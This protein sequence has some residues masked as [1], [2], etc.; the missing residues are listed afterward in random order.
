MKPTIL[1]IES[2][3]SDRPSLIEGLTRKGY[4]VQSALNGAS[5]LKLMESCDPRAA[6]VDAASMRT[7][8]SR[9]CGSLR[10]KKKDLP[11][12]LIL[13]PGEDENENARYCADEVLYLPFTLQK[14]INRLRPYVSLNENK[15]M[16][17][18]PLKLDLKEHWV[19]CQGRKARLTPRLFILMQKLM[20]HP[21]ELL[22]RDELFTTLWETD[23]L[24]DTRSLDVHISWLRKA[25]EDDPRNPQFIRTERGLGYRLEI[26]KPSRPK[27][28]RR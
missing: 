19:H 5:A 14:L 12:L 8:G 21:G 16:E 20:Q 3:H 28:T 17:V 22:T 6:V 9:I 26:E 25:V 11:I 15:I 24:G 18:G 1:L 10:K 27:R 7:N 2:K 4:Q 13:N 23:Y